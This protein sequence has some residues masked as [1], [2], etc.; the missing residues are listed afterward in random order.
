M[1]TRSNLQPVTPVLRD[2][3]VEPWSMN[4]FIWETYT[5]IVEPLGAAVE[6]IA[7]SCLLYQS[8]VYICV[9]IYIGYIYD[10][11]L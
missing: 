10:N 8:F 3:L 5:R 2:A 11:Y 9:W 1:W 4:F 6:D 7:G